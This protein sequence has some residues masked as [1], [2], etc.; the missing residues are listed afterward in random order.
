MKYKKKPVVI[1]AIQWNGYN[2][3]EVKKFTSNSADVKYDEKDG[4]IL[5]SWQPMRR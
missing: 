2:L 4:N 3:E 1:E 5:Y